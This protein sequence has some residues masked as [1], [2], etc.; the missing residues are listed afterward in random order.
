MLRLL[1]TVAEAMTI[2]FRQPSVVRTTA[3]ERHMDV[4]ERA[5]WT[6]LSLVIGRFM[7]G[8]L[9]LLPLVSWAGSP[10][11]SSLEQYFSSMESLQGGFHQRVRDSSGRLIEESYGTLMVQRPGRFRWQTLTPFVQEI[12]ADGRRVWIHDPDLEQVT[13]RH[14]QQSLSNT[15]ADLL[16]RQ[17]PLREQFKIYHIGIRAYPGKKGYLEWIELV[18]R[19]REG[20]FEYLL[21]GMDDSRLQVIELEDSLG[22]KT[23]I[24]FVDLLF[25]PSLPDHQFRF[26][27]PE[28]ADVVGDYP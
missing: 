15:P 25:N 13:V 19:E 11:E 8:F 6:G 17:Q 4:P 5:V 23:Q 1:S 22:Q 14:Q 2:L 27:P 16:I 10:L 26:L 24:E 7:Q 21:V 9:L 3:A 12:V 28:G 20:G 18:P